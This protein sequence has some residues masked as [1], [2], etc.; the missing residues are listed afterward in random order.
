MAFALV[1][2]VFQGNGVG[3]VQVYNSDTAALI[4]QQQFSGFN[5]TGLD[6]GPNGNLYVANNGPDDRTIVEFDD[7]PL[8]LVNSLFADP[9][10]GVS[11]LD[12]GPDGNLYSLSSTGDG[13]ISIFNGIS[14]TRI[15]S[16]F[17]SLSGVAVNG[18]TF[19]PGGNLYVI[20]PFSGNLV[21][22]NPTTGQNLGSIPVGGTGDL[23]FDNT[24]TLF[25]IS[26]NNIGFVNQLGSGL[27]AT[28]FRSPVSLAVAPN[29][30]LFVTDAGTNS[31]HELNGQTG[32]LVKTF[33]VQGTPSHIAFA[34]LSIGE[35]PIS[36]PSQTPIPTPTPNPLPDNTGIVGTNGNDRLT[37]T[38][39]NDRISGLAGKDWL[40]GSGGDDF[41]NGGGS[42]DTLKGGRGRDTFVLQK[43]LGRDVIL[44]F[45]DRQDQ[46]ALFDQLRLENLRVLKQGNNVLIKAGGDTLALLRGTDTAQIGANDFI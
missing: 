18:L 33:A 36:P 7:A 16:F 5:P 41:L 46:F 17:V 8:N 35:T 6:F 29:G 38:A 32:T 44:D 13:F 3:A 23:A 4:R 28:G 9:P 25:F 43:G 19:G 42:G 14:G 30:N 1:V 34:N 26:N 20:N 21:V 39:A 15:G 37:G 24:G 10:S 2:S 12:F 11:D 40:V 31:I 27:F 22:L 45:R